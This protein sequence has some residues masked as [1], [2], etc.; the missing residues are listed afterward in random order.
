VKK[1]FI[2]YDPPYG[3]QSYKKKGILTG[4]QSIKEFMNKCTD[5]SE[6]EYI[7]LKLYE[8]REI[9]GYKYSSDYYLNQ[10]QLLFG[11][12]EK[13]ATIQSIHD[14]NDCEYSYEW[15]INKNKIYSAIELYN[16]FS[17]IPKYIIDPLSITL[18]SDFCWKDDNGKIL[19][20]D[21][22]E[23]LNPYFS[24]S[25][26]TLHLSRTNSI[27]VDLIFPFEN[28][29]NDFRKHINFILEYIPIELKESRMRI[30]YPAKNNENYRVRK[31][32]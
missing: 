14:K 11:I 23:Y 25:H 26:F 30:Y 1:S 29:C 4:Y 18:S 8:N 9:H 24:K 22:E 19:N 28:D 13:Q 2:K 10:I 15:K 17:P 5:T 27:I 32:I 12:V 6:F 21:K 31:F 3:G 16:S 20:Y 7:Y